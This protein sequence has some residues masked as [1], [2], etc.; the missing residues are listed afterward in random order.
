M[1]PLRLEEARPKVTWWGR[2]GPRLTPRRACAMGP[3]K[4]KHQAGFGEAV[5]WALR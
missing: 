2:S 4:S 3:G 5:P 1:E